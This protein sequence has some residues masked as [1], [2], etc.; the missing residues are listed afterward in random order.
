MS[1]RRPGRT[2]PDPLSTAQV[3]ALLDLQPHPEGG[4]Y[5]ETWR[6]AA[7]AATRGAGSAI[8]YL[9]AGPAS[10]WHRVDAAETWH[11]YAGGSVELAVSTDGRRTETLRLGPD[12]RAGERPQAVV[13]AGAWQR[14]HALGTWSLVGCTVSPAFVFERFEL[15]PDGWE[16]RQGGATGS[17]GAAGS[18]GPGGS[19]GPAGPGGST[20][21]R[22]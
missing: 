14:A 21:S 22:R 6:A 7:P 4:W 12:L 5:R 13:P 15:A 2:T 3:V 8:Y 9:L 20:G 1:P 16:P 11:F 10:R 17:T 18:T 19:T